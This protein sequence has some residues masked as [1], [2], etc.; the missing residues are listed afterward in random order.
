MQI[1]QTHIYCTVV[2]VICALYYY[3]YGTYAY[4]LL[5]CYRWVHFLLFTSLC[6]LWRLIS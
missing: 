3:M 1:T 4:Y 6:R 5:Y 2:E